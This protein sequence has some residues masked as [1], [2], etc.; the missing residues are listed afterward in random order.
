MTGQ[1]QP[2]TGGWQQAARPQTMAL[3]AMLQGRGVYGN[4]MD[5]RRSLQHYAAL[6]QMLQQRGGGR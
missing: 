2:Y 3:Q 1:Y 5:A 6:M 4:P